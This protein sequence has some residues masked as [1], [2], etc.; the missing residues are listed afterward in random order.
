VERTFGEL[1]LNRLTAIVHPE[2]RASI[3]VLRKLG[4][5]EESRAVVTGMNSIVYG[6]TRGGGEQP[7]PPSVV[8]LRPEPGTMGRNKTSVW[9]ATDACTPVTRKLCDFG[10]T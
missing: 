3:S 10:L 4:F 8:P 7:V 2:N 9:K 6:L 5:G 1:K